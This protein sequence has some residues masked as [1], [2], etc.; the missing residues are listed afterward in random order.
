[1]RYFVVQYKKGGRWVTAR[2][3]HNIIESEQYLEDRRKKY[4]SCPTRILERKDRLWAISTKKG[5]ITHDRKT[6]KS[7]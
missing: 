1:M 2:R 7:H 6:K 5:E 3:T 4:A